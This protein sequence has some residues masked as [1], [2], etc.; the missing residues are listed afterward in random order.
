MMQ[1]W[2]KFAPCG[3]DRPGGRGYHAA[4][5]FKLS[6]IG[7]EGS[8]LLIVGGFPNDDSWMCDLESVQWKRVSV[9]CKWA[10]MHPLTQHTFIIG[11][12]KWLLCES[13]P[14]DILFFK[15]YLNL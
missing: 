4:T 11:L 9:A 12:Q 8:Q 15:L 10:V 1:N 6:Q 7:L 13:I 5:H 3:P 14:C 2:Q